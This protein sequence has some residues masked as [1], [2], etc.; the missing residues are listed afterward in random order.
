MS[1]TLF[2]IGAVAFMLA[3]LDASVAEIES[4]IDL[5]VSFVTNAPES[6]IL[7][8]KAELEKLPEVA[9]VAYISREKALEAFRAR[10]QGDTLILQALDE[11]GDNP[12]GATLSVR[13]KDSS[14]YESIAKFLADDTALSASKMSFID[15][16]NFQ[17]NKAVFERLSGF[18]SSARKLGIAVSVILGVISVLIAFNTIRLIIY[19]SKDEISVM[20]LVGAT[21]RFVRSPFIVS[22]V[23][24]GLVAAALVLTIFFPLAWWMKDAT[25][26]FF[27][28]LDVFRYYNTNFFEFATLIGG[29]G[30]IA[31]ALSSYL[32]VRKYLKI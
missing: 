8:V 17:D 9:S 31:G 13:A 10:N 5:T 22:G 12:L 14:Q 25:K 18:V 30:L 23:L 29:S 3:M 11:I 26:Q 7:D 24:Y 6:G 1:V 27:S 4:K 16:V 2:T 28:G 19:I 21:S 32:A 20:R 15:R